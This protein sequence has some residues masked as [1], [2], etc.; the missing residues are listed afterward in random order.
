[1]HHDRIL[2]LDVIEPL[3]ILR[4]AAV[5]AADRDLIL[6]PGDGKGETQASATPDSSDVYLS[7]RPSG[8][9]CPA[10]SFAAVCRHGRGGPP[11]SGSSHTSHFV[12]ASSRP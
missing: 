4:K 6:E 9:I 12:T 8:E 5:S 3:S 10:C 2:G 1:V 11:S 7:Q